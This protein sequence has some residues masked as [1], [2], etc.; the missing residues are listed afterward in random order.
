MKAAVYCEDGKIRYSEVKTPQ[1]SRDEVLLKMRACGICGTDIAKL[2]YKLVRA[3]FVPGHEVAGDIVKVGA[4]VDGF[5]EGDRV[6][7]AHH[8]PCFTCMLCRRG[9]FTQCEEFKR[10]NIDPGGL[11]EFIRILPRSVKKGMLKIPTGISYETATLIEP[12]SCCLRALSDIPISPDDTALIIGAGPAGLLH[13]LLLRLL[14]A[15]KIIVCDLQTGRLEAARQLGADIVIN[16]EREKGFSRV[17]E[18]TNGEGATIVIVA[19]GKP[20]VLA[21]AI[22]LTAKGGRVIF[23]AECAPQSIVGLDP[24]LIY[25]SGITIC[26]S[27]SSTPMEQKRVLKLISKGSLRVDPLITHRFGL[28]ETARAF[29]LAMERKESIKIIVNN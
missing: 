3:P 4:D 26:G 18:Y 12:A 14:G 22:N 27:Y 9:F 6:I 8:I 29:T 5:E 7:V 16:P 20:K 19:V 2:Q 24:N 1:I 10:L 15:G 21:E 23:F 13:L 25:K 17:R 28:K 11:S